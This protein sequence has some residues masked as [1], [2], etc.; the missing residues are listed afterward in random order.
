MKPQTATHS[1]Q[2]VR[3]TVPYTT[4][5]TIVLVTYGSTQ[6]E[7]LPVS[8]ALSSGDGASAAPVAHFVMMQARKAAVFCRCT[9]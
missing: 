6:A 2:E 4:K 9:H 3:P 5:S 1:S 8:A 7:M